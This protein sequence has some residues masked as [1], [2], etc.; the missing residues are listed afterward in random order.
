MAVHEAERRAMARALELAA[1]GP[2]GINPQ[3]GAV[4]L[5]PAGEIIAEGWHHGAGTPHAE[6]DALSKLH[7]GDA[8]GATAVVTLEPCN[9]TGRT[10]PCAVALIEAGISRVIYALDDPGAMSGGGAQRLRGAGV[11]VE[12]GEQ[13]DGAR[14]LIADWLTALRLG[15]PHI[16]VKWAQSLDGRA[17]ADDGT[18]QWITGPAARADVH[19]RRAEADAILVG[20]GTV[21]A[22]DPALTARDG[23]ML[24]EHQPI[25]VVIGSRATPADAAVRRHPHEAL[26][27]DTDDLHSV[28]ADLHERGIQ[29]AFIEGGPT[30]ASAFITAGLAD[31]VLAYVAPVLLGGGRLA[32]TDIGVPTI[33]AARR[34]TIEEWVPLGADMLAIA[35]FEDDESDDDESDDNE[36]V[37]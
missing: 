32:L 11:E 27:Y 10:G 20:T 3:V 15:R 4:I 28:V 31:R 8:R 25:P 36:G 22:D 5:S 16:T 35:R 26:F 37:R 1:H 24:Y 21:L 19:R 13:A 33:A 17:A 7:D 14:A 2:R 9:H 29:N 6:V 18:S 12:A 23:D 30:L 34:L